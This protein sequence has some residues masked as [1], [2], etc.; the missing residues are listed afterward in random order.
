MTLLP[1]GLTFAR[2][3]ILRAWAECSNTPS[4]CISFVLV[5]SV[6]VYFVINFY[7]VKYVLTMQ[8]NEWPS[9][10]EW[11]QEDNMRTMVP[12]AKVIKDL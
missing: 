8:C 4:L 3:V 5:P 11:R 6:V 9:A 2:K 10:K 1:Q 7:F 12:Y